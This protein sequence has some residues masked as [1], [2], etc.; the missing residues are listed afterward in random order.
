[1]A[2][3]LNEIKEQTFEEHIKKGLVLVDFYA[4]WCGPCRMMVPHL[5]KV[6]QELKD[7]L[8]VLKLDIEQAQKTADLYRIT[9]IPTL[10]LFSEGEKIGRLEGLSDAKTIKEFIMNLKK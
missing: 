9:S 1:M 5:E 8:V 10:I 4:H 2:S 3:T 7:F 6:A